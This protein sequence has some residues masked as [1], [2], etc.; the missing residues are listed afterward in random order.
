[1]AQIFVSHSAKDTA[2]K[3]FIN[4]AFATTQVAAK[5]EEIEAIL[6]GRRTAP[7][8][9]VDIAQSNAVFVLLGESVEKLRH[10]QQWVLWESGVAAGAALQSNK[11]VWVFEAYPD[12]GKLSVAIPHLDDHVCFEYSDPWLAYIRA[13]VAAYDDSHVLPAMMKGAGAGVVTALATENPAAGFAV[14]GIAALL[15]A[16]NKQGPPGGLMAIRCL[17]CNSVYRIHREPAW[18][19][20]RCP[21]C[22]AQLQLQ[23]PQV[24]WT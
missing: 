6:Q 2:L 10:T 14:G 9:V 8:I 7:Q 17:G 19:V 3:N 18:N 23:F 16:A 20:M 5:Y 21:V 1:M 12:R 11:P 13:I 22:N 15:L 4:Q 24:L